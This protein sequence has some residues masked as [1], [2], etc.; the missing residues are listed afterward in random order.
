MA[1]FDP[2][3][4]NVARM[5]DYLLGGH[6]NYA[7]DR[8]AT[9]RLV[10]LVPQAVPLARANRGFLRRAVRHLAGAGVRQFLDLGSGL[11]TQGS[12]H[13]IV[14][15]ARVVY[16]DRDPV[17]AA[18]ARALLGE[19]D[20]G[21]AAPDRRAAFL[22]ADLLDAPEVLEGA[23]E[24]LDLGR[25]VGILLVGIL[26]FLPDADGPYETVARLRE[27]VA[28]G[29]HL[30]ITHAVAPG[31][32]A[33]GGGVTPISQGRGADRPPAAIRRFFGDFALVEPGLVNAADWRPDRPRLAGEPGGG[34][35]LM[36][37]V[38]WKHPIAPDV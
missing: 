24:L 13:E 3:T 27:A 31:R 9:E 33:G 36:A 23:S 6:D 4:P 35:Y 17:V 5:Y 28:P 10:A 26:H 11:P 8:E 22:Q 19:G 15:D 14:P 30:V 1:E 38:G 32:P 21:R 25:P 16:V 29:S 2:H 7:V 20:G 12:V 18:H 37:G 34:S